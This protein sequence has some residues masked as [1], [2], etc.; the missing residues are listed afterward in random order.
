MAEIN[1]HLQV[2]SQSFQGYFQHGEVSV[3]QG[4][5]QDP[6]VFNLDSMDDNDE[7]K[8][9]LAELK[10]SKIIKIEF[11]SMQLDT[12]W[13]AQLNTLSQLAERA[14][15][16]LVPFATTYL[17]KTGCSTL[18]HIKTKARNGL[19]AKD[20]MRVAISQKRTSFQHDH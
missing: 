7:M 1:E 13:C 11:D 4:W 14:L 20:D 6:F 19:D 15:E 5:M 9:D 3:A 8:D 10:V 16:V 2:L 18:L 12:F 17:C